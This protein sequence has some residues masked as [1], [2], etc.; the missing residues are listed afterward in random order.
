MM[1][2]QRLANLPD[3]FAVRIA[4]TR[5][6]IVQCWRAHWRWFVVVSA[7][8][9]LVGLPNFPGRWNTDTAVMVEQ[10]RARRYDDVWSPFITWIWQ[11]F[12]AIGI[13]AGWL[14]LGQVVVIAL[15]V[16]VVL[17]RLGVPGAWAPPLTFALCVSPVFY[18]SAISVMRD[19]WFLCA[20]LVAI[21]CVLSA[22]RRRTVVLLVVAVVLAIASRQNAAPAIAIVVVWASWRWGKWG[23]RARIV[24]AISA[25]IVAPLAVVLSLAVWESA[26]DVDQEHPETAVFVGDLDEMSGRVG[27]VLMPASVVDP[28]FTLDE[29]RT[30]S[31]YSLDTLWFFNRRASLRQTDAVHADIAR[32]WRDSVREYPIVYLKGRWRLFTRQIGW[33][34]PPSIAY[35]PADIGTTRSPRPHFPEAAAKASTYLS[36]F[37]HNGDWRFGGLVHRAWLWW[38]LVAATAAWQWIRFRRRTYTWFALIVAAHLS[39]LFF[40]APHGQF[41]FVEF[42]VEVAQLSLVAAVAAT[43]WTAPP[44]AAQQATDRGVDLAG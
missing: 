3:G 7:L 12:Y 22:P 27:Q 41:R 8:L 44:A 17:R 36:W 20:L 31:I 21:G 40:V 42:A 38:A 29:F 30:S 13:G 18:A 24:A 1:G 19:T 11:P 4:S 39:A 16:G 5:A 10:I 32:A 6:A 33:S 23:G 2:T 34:G 43:K 37:A 35:F 28:P 26:I 9:L 25:G 15:S 14:M